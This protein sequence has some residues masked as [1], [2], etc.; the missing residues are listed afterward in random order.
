MKKEGGGGQGEGE[1]EEEERGRERGGGGRGGRKNFNPFIPPF[2]QF[3]SNWIVDLNVKS[4]TMILLEEN[5]GDNLCDLEL[6]KYFL[7]KTSKA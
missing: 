4:E 2:K 7:D 5:T 1:G 6:G 3:N